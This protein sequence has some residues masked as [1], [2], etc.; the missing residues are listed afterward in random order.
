MT[1]FSLTRLDL[2]RSVLLATKMTTL[3]P[4]LSLA[5]R[6]ATVE[7]TYPVTSRDHDHVS[8]CQ[9]HVLNSYGTAIYYDAS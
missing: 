7:L 5:A 4:R 2:A 6:L 8:L 9:V 1:S 3:S